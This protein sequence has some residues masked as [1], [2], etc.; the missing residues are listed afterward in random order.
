MM[1]IT[2]FP[3]WSIKRKLPQLKDKNGWLA[4]D[5]TRLWVITSLFVLR[6]PFSHQELPH[7][8]LKLQLWEE[9]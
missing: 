1:P 4:L 9:T 5:V 7:M 8:W 3:I 2:M 6:K